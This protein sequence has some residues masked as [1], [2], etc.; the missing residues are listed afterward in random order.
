MYGKQLVNPSKLRLIESNTDYTIH[1]IDNSVT[2]LKDYEGFVVKVRN[3]EVTGKSSTNENGAFTIF[4]KM[5]NGSELQIRV[6]ADVTPKVT[7]SY[8][9]VGQKYDVIGGVS[10][11]VNPFEN[12]KVYYQIKLGNLAHDGIKILLK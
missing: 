3:F 8:V 5:E 10:L 7:D 6:D 9:V 2:S 12:N 4:G 11:Y 1:E